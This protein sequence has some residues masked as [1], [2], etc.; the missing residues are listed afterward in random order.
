VG[1]AGRGGI[2]NNRFTANLTQ[3]LTVKTI[4]KSVKIWQNYGHESVASPCRL[5][6]NERSKL[7]VYRHTVRNLKSTTHKMLYISQLKARSQHVNRTELNSTRRIF[8]FAN[9]R[10]GTH[11]LRTS[12]ALT[13]PLSLQPISTNSGGFRREPSRLGLPTPPWP[14]DRLRHSTPDKW[15]L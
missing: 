2:F 6:S 11:A 10:V 4:R 9:R 15:Q 8:Q 1:S 12:R 3:N 13:V 7:L 5:Q 14:T